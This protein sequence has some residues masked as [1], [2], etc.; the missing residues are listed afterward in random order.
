LD[1]VRSEAVGLDID[2]PTPPFWGTKMLTP[3][4]LSIEELFWYMD[5]QALIAGQ[6]QFRKPK[7]QT[8][9]EYDAFLAAK[10]HPVL[11]EW[12]A[13]LLTGDW[14]HPQ[15]IY[16]YFPAA[17]EG[18]SVHVYDPSVIAQGLTPQTATP[19]VT[20]TFP[21]QKSLRRLCI[22]DFFRPLSENTFDVFPMQ[23]VT[24][25]EIATE[26][27]QELFKGDNYTNYLYFH[28]MAV[29]MAE[30]LAEWSHARIRRELGYGDS[31]PDN[32]RDM[33]AQR[34]QGSRY[35]F[36][37][38][39]C[40][41][42]PDQLKQLELLGTDRMKMTMDESEQLYPEQ[43]TTALIVYHSVAKYFSA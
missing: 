35:S 1:D 9:E 2:R 23:A 38:P 22:A 5:L 25:G 12:K 16:G 17:A 19:V 39:A 40:P 27:A 37:Y 10:V 41:H 18:N 7:D 34:Y 24:M 29:Q 33:L 13:K 6:W 20:W 15:L 21:R 30:A 26:K 31:E 3:A 28:G 43:S 36:G 14:L 8:R 32:I 11:A 42:V 4:D